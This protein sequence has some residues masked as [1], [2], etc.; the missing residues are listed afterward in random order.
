M[1]IYWLR[2]LHWDVQGAPRARAK[3][4][5]LSAFFFSRAS[6]QLVGP[7]IFP[8]GWVRAPSGEKSYMK[9]KSNYIS[10]IALLDTPPDPSPHH[11]THRHSC[12]VLPA[13]LHFIAS[14]GFPMDSCPL[15]RSPRRYSPL[16]QTDPRSSFWALLGV[17]SGPLELL[18]CF[19]EAFWSLLGAFNA[20]RRLRGLAF[21]EC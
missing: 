6:G 21:G 10:F 14:F 3:C 2:R 20:R 18:L 16:L 11:R 8:P 5:Y 7:A 12:A 17:V 4:F 15:H 9:L 1:K 13:P 19:P